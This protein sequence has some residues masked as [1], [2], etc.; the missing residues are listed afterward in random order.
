MVLRLSWLVLLLVLL[1]NRAAKLAGEGVEVDDEHITT[2][3]FAPS[4]FSEL[5]S[6]PAGSWTTSALLVPPAIP[7]SSWRAHLDGLSPKASS[8]PRFFCEKSRGSAIVLFV[9]ER[10]EAARDQGRG[11]S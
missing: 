1:S 8:P 9:K 4:S 2:F 6:A 5:A 11:K 3:S 7:S 10:G